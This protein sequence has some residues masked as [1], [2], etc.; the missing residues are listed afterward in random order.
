M[1]LLENNQSDEKRF[2]PS[3]EYSVK[4]GVELRRIA[5]ACKNG[6]LIGKKEFFKDPIRNYIKQRW[7][8]LD[9]PPHE[10]PGWDEYIK[11]HTFKKLR[12]DGGKYSKDFDKYA[13]I[14]LERFNQAR[15]KVAE[16]NFTN[17]ELADMLQTSPTVISNW[18]MIGVPGYGKLPRLQFP[19][20]KRAKYKGRIDYY[21]NQQD[22]IRFLKKE[23]NKPKRTQFRTIDDAL[24]D[25]RNIDDIVN[26][27]GNF[28]VYEKRKY[29]PLN[30]DGFIK[31][32]KENVRRYDKHD[33]KWVDFKPVPMQI[34]FY[35]KVFEIGDNGRFKH[36]F[37][38]I[39]RPRG[40]FKSF[41]AILI[42]LFRFFNMAREKILLAANSKD[43][44]DYALYDE[45]KDIILNSPNLINTP[46]I[47]VKEKEVVLMSGRKEVFNRIKSIASKQ[48]ALSNATCIVFSEIYKLRDQQFISELE[49]SIRGVPNAMSIIESTVS[50]KGTYYHRQ[51]LASIENKS[52]YIYFQY[53]AD[54]HYNPRITQ[55]ELDLYKVSLF[56]HEYKMFFENK[57]EDAGS[58]IFSEA[59]IYEM[60]IVALDG[61]LGPSLELRN[62]IKEYLEMRQTFRKIKGVTDTS[63]LEKDINNIK[64]RF[65]YIDELYSIPATR[66]DLIN[67]QKRYGIRDLIIGMGLDRA[68]QLTSNS[69]RTVLSTVAKS[70]IDSDRW[71]C[72]VL[73]MFIPNSPKSI[74]IHR[75]IEYNHTEYGWI[76]EIDL[77]KSQCLDIWNWCQERAYTATL[78]SASYEHQYSMFLEMSRLVRAGLFKCP[79]IPIWH[80][81]K[82]NV[83]YEIPPDDQDDIFREEM[84]VFEHENRSVTSTGRVSG[85]FGSPYKRGGQVKPGQPNDDTIY[86]MGHAVFAVNRG[87]VPA[88]SINKSVFM[89]VMYNNDVIGTY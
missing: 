21:Y 13:P 82:G 11:K 56:P 30:V 54:K 6:Y 2:I 5:G 4:Y 7:T 63:R 46:G 23:L 88:S 53:Y 9:I 32:A 29:Y 47:E 44:S 59:E 17:K 64:K 83:Y 19:D 77:E 65:T 14:F 68:E 57:W 34:D 35:K 66:S 43:Q 78:Q 39:C 16:A 74:P 58:G 28:Y 24:K 12:K 72:F 61:K 22:I 51:Y 69:D 87:D 40:D 60:G 45:A 62:T 20:D 81:D 76:S 26:A 50:R 89:N 49:G 38:R 1:I 10:H 33:N 86:S 55:E 79:T 48:G 18:A 73:D 67:I 42:F 80:D 15:V 8:V 41:D 27:E 36:R 52:P 85:R 37:I 3:K 70:Y 71:I 84:R 75:R 25:N 31:W